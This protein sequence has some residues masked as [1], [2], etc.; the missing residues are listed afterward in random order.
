MGWAV[1]VTVEPSSLWTATAASFF[2]TLPSAWAARPALFRPLMNLRSASL[3]SRPLAT[4]AFTMAFSPR[5]RVLPCSVTL[6]CS[7][8]R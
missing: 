3:R 1:V 2:T 5:R 7:R 6:L 4:M 8:S